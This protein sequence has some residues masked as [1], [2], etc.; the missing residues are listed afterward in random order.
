MSPTVVATGQLTGATVLMVPIVLGSTTRQA[1]SHPVVLSV[2][3]R[4]IAFILYFNLI[5]SAGATNASL[6]TLLVPVSAIMLSSAFSWRA[7]KGVRACR[8]D[9]D[10]GE[11]DHH[12]RPAVSPLPVAEILILGRCKSP[13]FNRQKTREFCGR[14][15]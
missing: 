11:P 14:P 9:I 3:A 7:V 10:H 13:R 1:S 5:T 6:V 8:N 2:V 4:A 12:R 15:G